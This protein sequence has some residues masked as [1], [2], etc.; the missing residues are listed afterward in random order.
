MIN[1]FSWPLKPVMSCSFWFYLESDCSNPD[2]Y[3]AIFKITKTLN[4]E[5][6]AEPADRASYINKACGAS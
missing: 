4:G 6:Q 3:L 2:H 1:I 5:S